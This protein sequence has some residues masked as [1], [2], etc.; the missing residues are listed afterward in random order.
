MKTKKTFGGFPLRCSVYNSAL[1][2]DS[3]VGDDWPK[4]MWL[5][6]IPNM[7]SYP[8]LKYLNRHSRVVFPWLKIHF[9]FYIAPFAELQWCSEETQI[10]RCLPTCFHLLPSDVSPWPWPRGP[11]FGPWSFKPKGQ[12]DKRYSKL[13]IVFITLIAAKLAV[14]QTSI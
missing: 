1:L 12:H 9:N 11:R 3:F 2:H 8:R 4:Y 7:Y 10:G 5:S 13:L 14:S 6:L